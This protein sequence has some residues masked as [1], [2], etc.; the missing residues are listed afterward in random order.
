MADQS[1]KEWSDEQLATN[2]EFRKGYE[3]ATRELDEAWEIVCRYGNCVIYVSPD[4][5]IREDLGGWG[6]AE[7]PCEAD[8]WDDE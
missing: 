1:W 4:S 5:T 6:W 2:P 7:C 3:R 8:K